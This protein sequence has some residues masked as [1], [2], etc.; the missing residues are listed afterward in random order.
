MGKAI[1]KTVG[2]AEILKRRVEGLHQNT[3]T[4]SVEILDI[5]EPKEE[6]TGLERVEKIRQVSVITITLS[7]EGLDTKSAGYQAPLSKEEFS[8]SVLDETAVVG[9]GGGGGGEEGERKPRR[10]GQGGRRGRGRGRGRNNGAPAEGADGEG[11]AGEATTE[12]GEGAAAAAKKGRRRGRGKAK[13]PAGEGED[14]TAA[15][16]ASEN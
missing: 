11:E 7:T 4:S 15:V 14:T 3:A 2:I 16:P 9:D 10:N 6:T 1:N 8:K 13:K 12:G 5:W